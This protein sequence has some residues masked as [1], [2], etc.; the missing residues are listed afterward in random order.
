[1]NDTRA[2]PLVVVVAGANGSGKSTTAPHLLRDALKVTEFVNADP[3]AAGLSAF[4]PE[5][6][7]I[8]AGRIMLSRMRQLATAREN[9]AFETTLASR[10]LAPWLAE[11][12]C[13]GYDVHLLFLWL[14]S[15]EL[16]ASRVAERVRL[17][18]HDI[19]T[20][21]VRRRYRAGL[22]NFFRLYLPLANG[23][24][25]FDNSA[26]GLPRRIAAGEGKKLRVIDD[27]EIWHRLKET[28]DG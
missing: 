22:R 12:R 25:L 8:A 6:V 16:A 28:Y 14:P 11:L 19:P 20:D 21:T 27:A 10:S 13:R 24:Q 15:A 5:S 18:G 26:S 23:W 9:F 1:V 7:A 3:I 17:G 2:A 4:R